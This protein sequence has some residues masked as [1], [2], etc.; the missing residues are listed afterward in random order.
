MQ[1]TQ[2]KSLHSSDVYHD[3]LDRIERLTPG[4]KPQWGRMSVAQMLAHCAE[5]QE[6]SN[7]KPLE[8]T[9]VIAKLFKAAIRKMV[10]GDKPFPKNTRTHPLYKQ[11]SDRDFVTEKQRL[12]NALER[13]V[14]DASGQQESLHPLFGK[15]TPAESGWSMY[16]HLDHHLSQFG[17]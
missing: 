11:A 17:V 14:R 16:K 1:Q 10:V 7:G 5:I 12:L 6:V 3:C 2:H 8:N 15:M 13:F 4:S 9:P